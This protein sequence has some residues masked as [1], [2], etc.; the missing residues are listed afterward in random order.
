[1]LSWFESKLRSKNNLLTTM[2]QQIIVI[3]GGD[4]FEDYED[5]LNNLRIKEVTLERIRFQGWKENLG[6]ELG[7]NFDVIAP[8]MPNAQNARY[9]EWKIWF[10]RIIPLLDR[11]VIFVCHSLGGIFI[12]KYLSENE[13]PKRIKAVFLVGTPYHT[14]A[15]HPLVDFTITKPLDK[16]IKQSE[17]IFLYHS[18]DDIIVPFD[19]AKCY[20]KKIPDAVFRVFEDRGHFNTE[21][22]PEI[23]TDIKNI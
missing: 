21:T 4:V 3:H 19:N 9:L 2:K 15:R 18:K 11:R 17:K 8:K 22:F 6:K 5:Y 7:K 20:H 16:F 1:M 10:E 13:Y 23:L 14:P 12:V